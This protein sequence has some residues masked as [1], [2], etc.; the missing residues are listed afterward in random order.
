[1]S[2][3]VHATAVVAPG[4]RLGRGVTI[5]PYAVVGDGVELGRGTSVGPHAQLEG[6]AVF[7]DENRIFAHAV[8]G[9]EPQD[10]KYRGEPTRLVAGARNTFRE[11]T[12]VHRG[13]PS[14]A[15]ET[16]IG[17]ENYFMAY[18]HVAHDCRV[19][20][21]TVFANGASLAG[22]AEVGDHAV[23]SAFAAV[24]QFAR[25]GR[26]AFVGAYTQCRQDVLPFCKTEG[27]DAKTYGINTIGL[28]RQGFADDE[29]EAL[30]KAYRFL[31]KSR[32][33]TSQAIERIESELS[34]SPAVEELVRFI[35]GSKRGFHK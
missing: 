28:K 35:R 33:N 31:V 24:H 30:Q 8:L 27:T 6:P 11:F 26:S 9:F 14:G 1:M 25:I 32:L 12:T 15:G 4:A 22:H 18:S 20:S 3:D 5:G 13:S 7:G 17:D 2:V 21:S 34:G 10:V 16:V 19:G 29:I 23:V